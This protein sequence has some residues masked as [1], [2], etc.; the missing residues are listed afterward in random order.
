MTY[1][2]YKQVKSDKH[3]RF[4]S[5]IA[6]E[7]EEKYSIVTITNR[8]ITRFVTVYLNKKLEELN[9]E[10]LFFNTKF[11]VVQVFQNESD[12]DELMQKFVLSNESQ[13]TIV[14]DKIH[15]SIYKKVQK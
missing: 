5:E 1:F 7:I 3:Y 11:G 13:Y 9:L 14:I 4:A 15:Y 6:K 12:L 8:P 10:R 2:Y